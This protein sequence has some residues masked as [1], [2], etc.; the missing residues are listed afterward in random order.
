M[1]NLK[2]ITL[3]M[4]MLFLATSLV[5]SQEKSVLIKGLI[6]AA[7]AEIITV[8]SDYQIVTQKY[9]RKEHP[10][11][12]YFLTQLKMEV[13]KWLKQGYILSDS[14]MSSI[15][16]VAYTMFYILTKKE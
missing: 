16:D 14:G 2:T 1:K 10:E 15:G 8:Q 5:Y 11:E 13:D 6:M 7:D 9:K 3:L 12:S 4:T